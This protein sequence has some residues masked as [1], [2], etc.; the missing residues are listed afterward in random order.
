MISMVGLWNGVWGPPYNVGAPYP[1]RD[2]T[3]YKLA[4][5]WLDEEC[6]TI[7]D[8]GCGDAYARRFCARASYRGID[9]SR[10][11]ADLITDLQGYRSSTEGVL[12]RHVLEHNRN[13][14]TVFDNALQS[15]SKRLVLV[16]FTPFQ[17]VTREILNVDTPIPDIGFARADLYGA[18]EAAGWSVVVETTHVTA[19]DYGAETILYVERTRK[20]G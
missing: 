15:A 10:G 19:T 14:R 11:P 6:A 4:A 12:L 16:V 1:S 9:G 7:E 13:W 17:P 8:W 20:V 5:E 18:F 3:T 2:E